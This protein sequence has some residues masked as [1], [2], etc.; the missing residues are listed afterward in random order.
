MQLPTTKGRFLQ[1]FRSTKASD[2]TQTSSD[3][4]KSW[5]APARKAN[6]LAL[7][8]PSVGVSSLL[9][10]AES[11]SPWSSAAPFSAPVQDDAFAL[12]RPVTVAL[13]SSPWAASA[14]KSSAPMLRSTAPVRAEVEFSRPLFLEK[15]S[16]RH[17]GGLC[18]SC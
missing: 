5:P 14:Q 3:S 6:G 10:R 12:P 15:K 4:A 8:R 1:F 2:A 9:V 13:G 16:A 18:R 11:S 17:P 7:K